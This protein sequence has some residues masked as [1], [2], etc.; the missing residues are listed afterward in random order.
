MPEIASIA[1]ALK[2][3]ESIISSVVAL[4]KAASG[5]NIDTIKRTLRALYFN[6]DGVLGV[7]K[8]YQAFNPNY[9]FN[10]DAFMERLTQYE[11]KAR[12]AF[13]D[14][15]DQ[16]ENVKIPLVLYNFMEEIVWEKKSLREELATF[17]YQMA[18]GKIS[19]QEAKLKISDL[20]SAI[21]TLNENICQ[22]EEKLHG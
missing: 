12:K 3:L 1:G 11:P 16:K 7:L 20:V 8:D 17:S 19:P 13:S 10:N 15:L 4:G 18:A 9:A 21:E 5:A 14:L 2:I 22:A 6:D